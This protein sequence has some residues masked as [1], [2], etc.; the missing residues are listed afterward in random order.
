MPKN[1][2]TRLTA[3]EATAH[4]CPACKGR[5]AL[6]ELV[7]AGDLQAHASNAQTCPNCGRPVRVRQVLIEEHIVASRASQQGSEAE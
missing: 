4:D 6:V 5:P 7:D 2:R 3:L 1:L